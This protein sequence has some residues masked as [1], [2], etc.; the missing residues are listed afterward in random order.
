MRRRRGMVAGLRAPR[1]VV[2]GIKFKPALFARR[3]RLAAKG[4]ADVAT[5][6]RWQRI[7]RFELAGFRSRQA[8]QDLLSLRVDDT[9]LLRKFR[10]RER[11]AIRG[12]RS[13]KTA[14]Q[15]LRHCNPRIKS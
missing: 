1:L 13:V 10:R 3:G 6:R 15:N 7:E 12:F 2:P 4:P 14:F 5:V 8:D 9:A 11:V